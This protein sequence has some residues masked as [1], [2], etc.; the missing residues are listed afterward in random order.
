M[1]TQIT[2]KPMFS[3]T[4][5][6]CDLNTHAYGYMWGQKKSGGLRRLGSSQM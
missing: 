5:A 2:N 1:T 4:V 6:V 3:I